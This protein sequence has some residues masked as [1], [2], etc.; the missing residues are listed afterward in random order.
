MDVTETP[1]RLI[2]KADCPGFDRSNLQVSVDD[3]NRVLTLRGEKSYQKDHED[4]FRRVHERQYFLCKNKHLHY[5]VGT[6][7]L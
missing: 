7:L 5:A 4:E 3:K 6:E 1:D 2:V